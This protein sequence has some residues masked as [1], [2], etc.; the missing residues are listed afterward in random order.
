M[1]YSLRGRLR[2]MG[3]EL[4]NEHS[5]RLQC[6]ACGQV[7]S[8]NLRTGGSLPRGYWKCPNGCNDS[9]LAAS[10]REHMDVKILEIID[11]GGIGSVAKGVVNGKVFIARMVLCG[12]DGFSWHIIKSDGEVSMVERM[13]VGKALWTKIETETKRRR[14]M[15][16]NRVIVG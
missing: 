5:L 9:A 2:R 7:W 4:I 16:G 10:K 11:A 8:P 3:V 12:G 1:P 14:E 13:A 15:M 6:V